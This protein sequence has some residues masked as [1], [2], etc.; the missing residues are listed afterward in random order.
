MGS[1]RLMNSLF[2]ILS[3]IVVQASPPA[4]QA[5]TQAAA[6]EPAIAAGAMVLNRVVVSLGVCVLAIW[7]FRCVIQRRKLLLIGTPGRPSD[8]NVVHLAALFLGW[9]LLGQMGGRAASEMLGSPEPGT[10]ASTMV[11][12]LAGVISAPFVLAVALLVARLAFR[13]GI[14]HGMG[15]SLRRPLV[16]SVRG[17]LGVLAVF[18]ICWIMSILAKASVPDEYQ[19]THVILLFLRAGCVGVG[20]KVMG[21]LTALVVAPVLEEVMFRGILQ[22]ALRR[23]AGSPWIGILLASVI[24]AAIHLSWD[25]GTGVVRG[26]ENLPPLFA[27]AVAL[28]YNYERSGRLW[29]CILMHMLFN[30]INLAY[31]T[32]PV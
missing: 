16:D 4:T 6:G 24:F 5:T 8:L 22:T 29:P 18:P 13:H 17:V 19:K 10:T 23:Y 32:W 31:V 20:W 1:H 2:S 26:W 21:G 14:V 12:L 30:G 15:L 11:M 28:G 9:F 3:Q 27:L 7:I 25:L